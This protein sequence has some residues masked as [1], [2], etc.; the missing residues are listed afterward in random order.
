MKKSL[1]ARIALPVRAFFPGLGLCL[2]LLLCS[3]LP[4][5]AAGMTSEHTLLYYLIEM[6]RRQTR[7]C[8]GQGLPQAPSL[9]P[10]EALR[11]AAAQ[12]LAQGFSAQAAGLDQVPHLAANTRG[13][14]ARQAV[15]A[16]LAQQCREV[17]GQ[18]YRYIGAAEQNGRWLVILAAAEPGQ[19]PQAAAAPGRLPE[20]SPAPAGAAQSR[21]PQSAA[22]SG[23]PAESKGPVRWIDGGEARYSSDRL[24]EAAPA[25]PYVVGEMQVDH[26]GRPV[27][28]LLPP[29]NAPGEPYPA[30]LYPADPPAPA[31]YAAA[32]DYS[33]P[34]AQGPAPGLAP[35]PGGRFAA[36][37]EGDAD[38]FAAPQAPV[39]FTPPQ[40]PG[41]FAPRTPQSA[42]PPAADR[43]GVVPLTDS[44]PPSA[45]TPLVYVAPETEYGQ[46][47]SPPPGGDTAYQ[48]HAANAPQPGGDDA[49]QPYTPNPAQSGPARQSGG[50][51]FTGTA[52]VR[53][54][55]AS[56]GGQAPDAET[57]AMLSLINAER[58][59]GGL[60]GTKRLPPAQALSLDP[61][62]THAALAHAR[63]M[64]ARNYFSS[65]SPE[66][67]E[68]GRR[69][70]DAGYVWGVVAENLA[71][72]DGSAQDV[73]MTWLAKPGQCANLLG[74]EYYDAGLGRDAS[75]RYW[76]LILAAPMEDG[77]F[78]LQ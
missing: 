45:Q 50:T 23:R 39:P 20:D 53:P 8:Q 32:P 33:A 67:A 40:S 55:G 46:A 75:G 65:S 61:S 26:S 49:Y 24:N 54:G 29:T 64:A 28:P 71:A 44:R 21:P 27:G 36:G 51:S 38:S 13:Q 2:C 16:L 41:P 11:A 12:G 66:G 56:Y 30:E 78:I 74:A 68:L 19:A 48:P 9:L 76:V 63:D 43:Q 52:P 22:Q 37:P 42:P 10:S 35:L 58:A 4:V 7:T 25:D 3:G 34:Q 18:D 77:A 15:N 72:M 73:L 60:C 31:P 17:M 70:A 59:K 62:L 47:G 57:G 5:F 1:P 6:Q 69:V 14:N